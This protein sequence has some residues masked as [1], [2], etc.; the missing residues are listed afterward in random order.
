MYAPEGF[1]SEAFLTSWQD[2]I[3]DKPTY[4]PTACTCVDL[5]EAGD[6]RCSEELVYDM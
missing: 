6:A 3:K 5:D 4:C 2:S 1:T